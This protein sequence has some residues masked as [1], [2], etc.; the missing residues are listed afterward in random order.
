MEA[1]ARNCPESPP[2]TNM[3][4]RDSALKVK[5]IMAGL[6]LKVLLLMWLMH[7]IAY[8]NVN[9]LGYPALI[10]EKVLAPACIIL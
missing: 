10:P 5:L 4:S 3:E 2:S 6:V 8:L 7:E 9:S 1:F